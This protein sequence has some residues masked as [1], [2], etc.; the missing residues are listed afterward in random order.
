MIFY[1]GQETLN[2]GLKTYFE[3]YSFKNTT[4]ADFV[5]ELSIAAKKVGVV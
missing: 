4:L 1:F 5:K 2:E 3:K